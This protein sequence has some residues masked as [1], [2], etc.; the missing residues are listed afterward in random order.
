MWPPDVEDVGVESG[1]R[2]RVPVNKGE[3]VLIAR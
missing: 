3:A 2:V 1:G